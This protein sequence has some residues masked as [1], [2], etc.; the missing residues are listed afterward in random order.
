MKATYGGMKEACAT[1]NRV[2]ADIAT[3]LLLELKYKIACSSDIFM[4]AVDKSTTIMEAHGDAVSPCPRPEN[5]DGCQI[6]TPD[7]DDLL[8]DAVVKIANEEHPGGY[9]DHNHA[10]NPRRNGS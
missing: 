2:A 7:H 8:V 4:Q 6:E 10:G 9:A 5:I 1:L 3:K